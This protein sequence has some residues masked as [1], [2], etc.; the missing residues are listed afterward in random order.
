MPLR[1][2]TLTAPEEGATVAS[3]VEVQG[4]VSVM[5]F[6]ANLRGRV[7]DADGKVVGEEPIQVQP[8]VE[9]ELGGP[10]T[11]TGTIPF[12]VNVA[13]PGH[14]EV[15]EISARDGSIVV[16]ATVVVTLTTSAGSASPQEPTQPSAAMIL[17]REG[18]I[19]HSLNLL[20]DQ[21]V[22]WGHDNA[23][24]AE[25]RFPDG[26]RGAFV[27]V[28]FSG[29]AQGYQFLYRV[30]GEKVVLVDFISGPIDWGG[31]SLRDFE[32][33]DLAFPDLFTGEE[34]G[35]R[36]VI[37]VTGAGHA[38]TGLWL[39][40]YFELIEITEEGIHVLF[41]GAHA[42]I[43]ANPGGWERHYEYAYEDLDDDG[44]KE[45]I[46]TG[47]EC[48]LE[49]GESGLEGTDC[50]SVERVFQ[51]DGLTYVQRE[52]RTPPPD[53]SEMDVREDWT[54][55]SPGGVW[56]ARGLAAF[57]ENG[58]RDPDRYYTRLTVA[59][60][61][62]SEEWTVVER[63]SELALGYVTP[64]PLQW[65]SDGNRFYFTN[66]PVP[67]GC[68]VFVNGSDLQRVDLSDGS[69]TEVV[70]AVGLWLSLSPDERELAYV[71]YGDRGLVLRDLSTGRER[72]TQIEAAQETEDAHVGHVVWSP[73]GEGLVL[74]VAID[75]C[76]PP[77]ARAHTI[78]HVDAETLAQT[79]LIAED[80][81]LFTSDAWSDRE[82]VSLRDRDGE[83]WRLDP[84]TRG[85]ETA[86]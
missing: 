74:T 47:E 82:R 13:G 1:D 15:A 21:G 12:Q 35:D 19:A 50:E 18:A 72:Q 69:V 34:D 2:I 24:F 85:L 48:Q 55:T 8:D 44:V 70:P 73:D 9:G 42:S 80:E 7:Y 71:G 53:L 11:F 26:E 83:T 79:T 4:R 46:Q 49:P 14:V 64:E 37:Q 59:R 45:I 66:R 57:P 3:P 33:V 68:A 52:E 31:W 36:E 75:A 63:W 84:E 60:F 28:G 39:D 22:D 29:I 25:V 17:E 43:N 62:S 30:E 86:D 41:S 61:D 6:E 51:F 27:A 5:P 20:R 67:D 40:G 65:S 78:V 76:G 58:E 54:S 23:N 77:E 81:R 16:S 38:G 10:G 56:V 32:R